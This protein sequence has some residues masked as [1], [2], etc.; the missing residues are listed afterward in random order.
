MA[1]EIIMPKNGMAMEEGKLIR[2]LKNIGDEVKKD[3]PLIEI[4]TDKITMEEPAA[5]SGILLAKW[6]EDGDTIP[7]LEVIGWIGEKGEALPERK[8]LGEATAQATLVPPTA[9]PLNTAAA[10]PNAGAIAATPYAKTLAAQN[11]VEL[12][13]VTATGRHG[14]ITAA[15]VKAT[16]LAGRMAADLRINLADVSGTGHGGKITRDDILAANILQEKNQTSVR[17][18]MSAMRKAVAKNMVLSAA[19]PTVTQNMS[20]DVTGLLA[21]R[22][23]INANREEKI[24]LND[25]ILKAVAKALESHPEVLVSL[26]GED[27]LW[28]SSINLG[29]A[30][31][32]DDGLIVPVVMNADTMGLD[33]ISKKVK[34]LAARAK[35]GNLLP[36]E[37][38]G[39][40][41]TVTNLGM[42]GVETFSPIINLPNAAILGVCAIT[43][44]LRLIDGN[45]EVRK[46]MGLS[47]TYDHRLMDGATA[48][49]FSMTV[50][51][52]LENPMEIL[53]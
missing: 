49:K 38:R 53:L 48:G 40:T 45:V 11:G 33:A 36:N 31:A 20:A 16:P 26:D 9:T 21:L 27:V 15:D 51:N 25:M 7:V 24:T 32:L 4:E 3:E 17:K 2:W 29:V 47:V 28:H 22:A 13:S 35:T 34:D 14:E 23:K 46:K 8:V 44:E 42:Y 30:V 41:F 39:S 50:R 52:L 12:A 6:A 19:T 37:Y 10:A 18:P 43:D 1:K 5:T